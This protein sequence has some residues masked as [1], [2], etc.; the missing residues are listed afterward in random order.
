MNRTDVALGSVDS[1]G[2]IDIAS[3][4]VEL[5]RLPSI[6][7]SLADGSSFDH[8]RVLLVSTLHVLPMN[9]PLNLILSEPKRKIELKGLIVLA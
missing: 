5:N 3:C 8:A 1:E 6:L 4:L 2:A 7:S 9:V